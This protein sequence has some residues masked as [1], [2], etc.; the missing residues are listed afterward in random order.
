MKWTRC[1]KCRTCSDRD[2]S[3]TCVGCDAPLPEGFQARAPE[4][5]AGVRK[6]LR[7]TFSLLTLVGVTVGAC[8][9]I[10]AVA[11]ASRPDKMFHLSVTGIFLFSGT[12]VFLLAHRVHKPGSKLTPLG[13]CF[14]AGGLILGLV[15]LVFVVCAANF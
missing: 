12:V 13:G 8:S 7:A 15:L 2:R 11:G 6:D 9:A 3:E 10:L 4:V 5:E 1:P 14:L